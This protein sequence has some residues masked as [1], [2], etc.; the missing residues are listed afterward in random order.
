[1]NRVLLKRNAGFGV[2]ATVNACTKGLWV[3]KKVIQGTTPDNED[4]NVL[5]IDSEGLGALDEDSNHDVRIFSL[6]ILLS[7]YFIYNSMGSI[8]ENAL[9][10]LSLVVNLT[11]HIQIRTS[12]MSHEVDP[13]EYS[14]YFPSFMWVVRDF[15]LQLVDNDG[16]S[17]TAKEYLDKALNEQKGFSES[18]EQKN[19]IRKLL[20]CFFKDRDCTCVVRPLTSEEDLQTLETKEFDSLREEFKQQIQ[21]LRTKVMKRIKPKT[22]LNGRKLNGQMFVG[23]VLNYVEAINKGAVPNIQSA[24]SYISKNECQKAQEMAYESFIEELHHSFEMNAPMFEN[25]LNDLFKEAKSQALK[26]FSQNAVGDVANEFMSD[27]KAK[28]KNKYSQI[29]AENEKET[30]KACQMYL[31]D[32]FS[33]TENKLRNQEYNDFMEFEKDI[34]IIEQ[35]FLERGPPG[36][37]RVSICQEFTINALIDGCEYF[38]RTMKNEITLQKSLNSETVS[39]LEER[40]QELKSDLIKCKE[41]NDVKIRSLENEKAQLSAK[42]QSMRDSYNELKKEKEISEK[43]WKGRLQSERTENNRSIEEYKSRMYA[44]EEAAKEAQR[45]MSANESEFEKQRALQAQK[46]EFSENNLESYKQKEKEYQS[47]IKNQRKELISSIKESSQKYEDKIILLNKKIETLTEESNE[48][49][50]QISE[51]EQRIYAHTTTISEKDIEL[52]NL[53]ESTEELDALRE[54]NEQLKKDLDENRKSFSLELQEERDSLQYELSELKI[55][56]SE[57]QN[58][59]EGQLSKWDNEDSIKLQK[60]EFLNT[61]V[62]EL[63]NQID[64]NKKTHDAML[65]AVQ[66]REYEKG[67]AIQEADKKIEQIKQDHLKEMQEMEGRFEATNK[68]LTDD[69]EKSRTSENDFKMKLKLLSA[70]TEKTINDLRDALSDTEAQRDRFQNEAKTLETQKQT[71]MQQSEERFKSKLKELELEIQ[72]SKNSNESELSEYR[73]K[74]EEDLAQ[75]KNFYETEKDRLEKRL[76]EEKEKGLRNVEATKEDYEQ[77]MR[78]E[79]MQHDD[80][81]ELLQDDLRD[82]EAQLQGLS[83]Q[84]EHEMSMAE[85]KTANLEAHLKETKKAL[86]DIQEKHAKTLEQQMNSFNKERREMLDKA[87]EVAQSLTEKEKRIT[88]LENQN[89]SILYQNKKKDEELE[90]YRSE[91]SVKKK[92]AEDQ[93]EKMREEAQRVSD[94]MI[95]LK[96]EFGKTEALLIQKNEHLEKR[97]EDL[98]KM[99]SDKTSSFEEKLNMQKTELGNEINQRIDQITAEKDKFLAKFE[100]KR[101]ALKELEKETTVKITK[102]EREKAVCEEKIENLQRKLQNLEETSKGASESFRQQYSELQAQNAKLLEDTEQKYSK[103][104]S[105]YDALEKEKNDLNSTYERENAL[106]QNKVDFLEDQKAQLKSDLAEGHKKL[107]DSISKLQTKGT[108]RD[109]DKKQID[110]FNHFEKENKE[111]LQNMKDSYE[112]RIQELSD[113][114]KEVER[115]YLSLKE[116]HELLIRDNEAVIRRLETRLND[117]QDREKSQFEEITKL[118]DERDKM[119]SEGDSMFEKEKYNLKIRINEIEEK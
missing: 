1:M 68:R 87:D 67:E 22:I 97:N 65:K 12:G 4:I 60:I 28:L 25:D 27:L 2:G 20:K 119:M 56:F 50:N 75:L 73:K 52:S 117:S 23:L 39:K 34:K 33:Q 11:K 17:I 37:N 76:Q 96:G 110:L 106:L 19:R 107:E 95:K 81:L 82:K 8:D 90:T 84:F 91:T 61:Q 100:E 7:S 46:L 62:Q 103:L 93:I 101:K 31:Q 47:E 21:Q 74:S 98:M 108:N 112:T 92:S 44:S 40:V 104:K 5:I 24:W 99:M 58:E 36:P 77:R 105:Q 6:A 13:E 16:E 35:D 109:S 72:Q 41:E 15:A 38:L 111:K 85:Q 57:K 48:K 64:E 55:K 3:W 71:I 70:E 102:L 49:D 116:K 86:D 9:Q 66:S 18:V 54:E 118:K 51:L 94:E 83:H 88:A 30:R 79:Q 113:K 115:D 45:R 78:D 29:K 26:I 80:E 53:K 14:Q 42:E 114:Y 69:L 32:M 89:E 63:R 59:L 10:S 43:E